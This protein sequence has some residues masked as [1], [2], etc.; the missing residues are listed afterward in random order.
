MVGTNKLLRTSA[1]SAFSATSAFSAFDA[2][3]LYYAQRD[4]MHRTGGKEQHCTVLRA[5][6]QMICSNFIF[7]FKN[8]EGLNSLTCVKNY[9]CKIIN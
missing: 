4:L 7:S 9:N 1:F 3:I 2:A 5:I 8:P 6:F